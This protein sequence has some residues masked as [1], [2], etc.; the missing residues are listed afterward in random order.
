V[1]C[2]LLFCFLLFPF[3]AR[4][5]R[6]E[7]VCTQ[8]WTSEESQVM[9]L[10]LEKK[11]ETAWNRLWD[12]FFYP[13]TCMFY[14]VTN[15]ALLPNAVSVRAQIPKSNASQTMEDVPMFGGI[16]LAALCDRYEMT[17][18]ESLRK[19]AK[20]A[21]T[22][23]R[24]CVTAH[25]YPGFVARGICAEDMK[26]IYLTSSIDQ[27]TH[28]VHG[29]WRY[30]R[31]P[32]ADEAAKRQIREMMSAI[33]DRMTRNVTPENGYNFLRADDTE[34]ERSKGIC[35]MWKNHPHEAARLPMV[36]AVAWDVGRRKSDYTNWRKYLPE[37][38]ERTFA[39][40]TSSASTMMRIM[41][42]YTVLQMQTSLEALH[43]IEREEAMRQRI[44]AALCMVAHF[45]QDRMPLVLSNRRPNARECGELSLAQLMCAGVPFRLPEQ[46]EL[47][48]ALLTRH[49]SPHPEKQSYYD[50]DASTFHCLLGAYWKARRRGY[51]SA[52]TPL[53]WL[54]EAGSRQAPRENKENGK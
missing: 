31:S 19:R 50:S 34:D 38:L 4:G 10:A 26:S 36:Y 54:G 51:F 3:Q 22:G 23:L 33:A 41:P 32:L 21:Y 42:A 15:F 40:R 48:H 8:L 49:F 14:T 6:G 12:Q 47:R 37:G 20:D 39:L 28:C 17:H 45:A 35:R 46:L 44:G 11:A 27:V 43:G 7:S 5:E 1:F 29:F 24:L 25:D 16:M 30:Y 52:N 18:E 9:N 13:K 2:F 53:P